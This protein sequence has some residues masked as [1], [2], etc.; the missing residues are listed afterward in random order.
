MNFFGHAALAASHFVESAAA[1]GPDALAKLCAGSMLPDFISMLQLGRPEVRDPLV[2]QGVAFH[3]RTDHA[4]HD[5]SSF[6][7]LSRAA[8]A[9]LSARSLPRGP[10]RAVAHIGIEILL[11]EVMAGEPTARDAY[12]A[13]LGVPLEAALWFAAA[14]DPQRLAALRAALLERG[15]TQR[16]PAPELVASRIRRTLNGRPRLATDDAGE[17][18]LGEWVSQARPQVAAVA[19]EL[20][21]VLRAQLA[22]FGRAE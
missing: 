9:W 11:D 12:R 6:H 18:L 21:A 20:L 17:A 10:A 14:S 5:L 3:H 15:A 4:F 8:F 7:D 16:D 1:L 19:P 22:N 13:A 2:A